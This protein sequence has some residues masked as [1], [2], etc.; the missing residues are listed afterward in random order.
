MAIN[1]LIIRNIASYDSTGVVLN[2]LKKL[3]FFF[4]YN[5]SGKSTIARYLYN[6]SLS[7]SEQR[8]DYNQCE[9][10][11]YDQKL[12]SIIVFDED[13]KRKNFFDQNSL[14]GVFSLNK[15]NKSIDGLIVQYEEFLKSLS[16]SELSRGKRYD[17]ICIKKETIHKNLIDYCFEQ[18]KIFDVFKKEKL[19]YGNSKERHYTEVCKYIGR[20]NTI[21]NL[22]DIS[23]EYTR[24]YDSNINN[25]SE[26]VDLKLWNEL[27]LTEENLSDLLNEIIIGNADVDIAKLINYLNLSSWVSQGRL[28]M[29]KTNGRCPFCQQ[30]IENINS[31]KNKFEQYF[32]ADFKNRIQNIKDLGNEY[33]TK[34]DRLKNILRNIANDF[35]TD[36]TALT[37]LDRVTTIVDENIQIIKDKL[38]NP[39]EKKYLKSINQLDPDIIK[40]KS[41]IDKNNDD[42]HNIATLQKKWVEKCWIYIACC[43]ED[44]IKTGTSYIDYLDRILNQNSSLKEKNEKHASYIRNK[45]DALRKLTVNTTEAVEAINKILKNVGFDNFVIK[46]KK[47]NNNISEYYLKRKENEDHCKVFR[48]LSEGEKTFISF[49]Y[50]YQLCIGTDDIEKNNSAKKKIIVI[51]D[52]VSSLDSQILFIVTTLIHRLI[53]RRDEMKNEFMNPN[54]EQV[55]IFTHNFYFYKEVSLAR[56]PF[57]TDYYHYKIYKE[58]S[59]TMVSG[60]RNSHITDDYSLMWNTL[61][62]IKQRTNLDNS[63][64]LM[65]ATLMRRIIDTYIEFIGMRKNNSSVT[66]SALDG[67]DINSPEYIVESAFISCINDESH[68]LSPLDDEYYYRIIKEKPLILFSAFKNI[69]RNI[70]KGHYE[71]MMGEIYSDE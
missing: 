49:L 18:R 4:G 25:V 6:L 33:F 43:C 58:N 35:Q 30:K 63:S 44:K 48:S 7:I 50:F 60:N 39:N 36:K 37:L 32:D 56:R 12:H 27:K 20:S 70:G 61:K 64:N 31:L 9:Q 65:L 19:S 54:I 23:A 41:C 11:G 13:F 52:P 5:G 57:C 68:S 17:R 66:W 51:D 69:F 26:N 45:I 34:A 47:S 8:I 38:V 42:F 67:V 55:F 21:E 10:N 62:E 1:K 2:D 29:D 16:Q 22:D 3:N 40:L 53:Q 24:L 28:F 59:K 71:M 46:E 14:K 15:S